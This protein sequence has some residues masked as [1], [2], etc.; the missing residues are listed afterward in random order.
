MNT[1]S[2]A[3]C[4]LGGT[5]VLVD[6]ACAQITNIHNF[7]ETCPMSDPAVVPILSDFKIRANG[8]LV[9]NYPCHEPI[10][11][12]ALSDY[13][14]PLIVLQ[15]LRVI[16][17]MDRG[18]SGHL[19]WTS[20]TLYDWMKSQIRGID[21]RTDVSNSFCCENLP[22]GRYIV[23]Q[24]QNDFNRDFDRTWLG[25]AGNI[26]L[27]AHEVRHVSGIGHSSCCGIPGGCDDLFATNN[28][29]AYGVQWWLEKAWLYGE[30]NVG[31]A[32]ADPV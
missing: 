24:A 9:E 25:I 16:Y 21:V 11:A 3:L 14:D 20:G 7:L 1:T 23:V 4:M 22:D 19:P 28:L 29:S 31:F 13:T 12:L 5:L 2:M 10:S 27:Y 15:G 8:V 30:I 18:M 32:C 17:Y 26:G 6:S